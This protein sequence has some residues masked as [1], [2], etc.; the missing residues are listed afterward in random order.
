MAYPGTTGKY[1]CKYV[2]SNVTKHSTNLKFY[3]P[4]EVEFANFYSNI[5]GV[6]SIL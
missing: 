5:N 6:C 4:N 3:L 2:L 1:Y